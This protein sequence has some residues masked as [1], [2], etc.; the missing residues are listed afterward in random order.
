MKELGLNF[1]KG[2]LPVY[3]KDADS[4]VLVFQGDTD[5]ATF[6]DTLDVMVFFGCLESQ[7]EHCFYLAVEGIYTNESGTALLYVVKVESPT[8][9]VPVLVLQEPME[10]DL[11]TFTK[12]ITNKKDSFFQSPAGANPDLSSLLDLLGL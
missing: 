7:P 5:Q 4:G 6:E 12:P 10:I 11:S 8:N 2:R 1:N 3:V 9:T